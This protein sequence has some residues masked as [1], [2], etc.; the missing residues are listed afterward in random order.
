MNTN[1]GHM[2]KIQDDK[3]LR[4]LG[5]YH[6]GEE[7]TLISENDMIIYCV[8]VITFILGDP[9]YPLL[10]WFMRLYSDI[11]SPRRSELSY[12]LRSCR[13]VVSLGI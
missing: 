4:R 2:R 8:S 1:V 3:M 6:R 11:T 7:G 12:R 13:M 9:T 10:P 5:L